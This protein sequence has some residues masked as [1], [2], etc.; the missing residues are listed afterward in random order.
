MQIFVKIVIQVKC[1]YIL[2]AGDQ[3][4]NIASLQNGKVSTFF[5][6]ILIQFFLFGSFCREMMIIFVYDTENTC[7]N[8]DIS[9]S[10][11]Y[12][13]PQWVPGPQKF[14]LCGQL[15]G[16]V[17][18]LKTLFKCPKIISLQS[19]KF[20]VHEFG[21]F[22]LA[23]GTDRNIADW[24][25]MHRS[26]TLCN[27]I[28]FFHNGLDVMFKQYTDRSKFSAKLYHIFETY[29][30]ILTY[31]GNM[32]SNIPAIQLPKSASNVFLD[33]MHILQC[34]QELDY[35]LG[36]VMLYHNKYVYLY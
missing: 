13:H 20:S 21:R 33:A 25:V 28:R 6:F 9:E 35:V 22:L 19:G 34:C 27:F 10:L 12:F 23:V 32:F 36:G 26:K 4:I 18:C 3:R 15:V 31:G 29:Q 14:A 24:V 17:Q 8:D 7:T 2:A 16:T 1:V 30:R 11:L 5:N